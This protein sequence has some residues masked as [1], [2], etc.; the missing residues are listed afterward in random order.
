MRTPQHKDIFVNVDDSTGEVTYYIAN[1]LPS[2]IKG[3][4]CEDCGETYAY[5][6]ANC[7]YEQQRSTYQHEAEHI[8]NDDF[9]SVNSADIIEK[10]R[11]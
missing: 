10:K 8:T 2:T 11:H 1:A 3:L 6:N 5:I 9:H 4:V 7:S